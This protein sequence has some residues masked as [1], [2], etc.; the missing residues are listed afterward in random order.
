MAAVS[1]TRGPRPGRAPS[2]SRPGSRAAEAKAEA[3]ALSVP[4]P[5]AA[6]AWLRCP[7]RGA[8]RRRDPRRLQDRRRRPRQAP[9]LG[10]AGGTGRVRGPAE[11][12][13]KRPSASRS[14]AQRP[15]YALKVIEDPVAADKDSASPDAFPAFH[16]YGVSGTSPGRS[17]TQ[18]YGRPKTSAALEKMGIDVKGKIVLVRYGELFR[19]LKVRN[20]QKRGRQGDLDLLRP[21]RRRLRQGAT[22]SPTGRSARASSL[23]RG[24]V[25]FL[26][27]GPGDPSTPN[28]PVDQGGQAAPV[29]PE[30]R[31]HARPIGQEVAEG[32]DSLPHGSNPGRF[33]WPRDGEG[34]S[35]SRT[36]R[37][38]PA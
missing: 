13:Q 21:R 15:R 22:P 37:R 5:D 2:D 30:E 11:L 9:L 6:R 35:E 10:L 25:Q 34:P 1:P 33:S 16:G 24:S 12:P 18:T 29:R 8:P 31:L 3:H 4:S 17:S 27:L 38:R 19:G 7:D 32:T 14:S 36:G 26:S 23:Q 20:A 28:G